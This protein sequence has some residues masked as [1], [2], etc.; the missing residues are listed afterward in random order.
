M[1]M[2][3]HIP[4][5]QGNALHEVTLLEVSGVLIVLNLIEVLLPDDTTP[6]VWDSLPAALNHDAILGRG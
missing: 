3:F 6:C 5:L 1:Q 2:C 4:R